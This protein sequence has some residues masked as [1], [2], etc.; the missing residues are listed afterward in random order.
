MITSELCKMIGI[1]YPLIQA[2]MGPYSTN[3]LAA[4]AANAGILGLVSTSGFSYLQRS[5][6]ETE[7]GISDAGGGPPTRGGGRTLGA[8]TTTTGVIARPKPVGLASMAGKRT[9]S[10]NM[11]FWIDVQQLPVLMV[12]ILSHEMLTTIDYVSWQRVTQRYEDTESP[13]VSVQM[14]GRIINYNLKEGGR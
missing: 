7:P 2:G 1:K 8:P 13:L 6:Y 4:A 12:R 9:F 11:S 5:G 14:S 3:R 10:Y